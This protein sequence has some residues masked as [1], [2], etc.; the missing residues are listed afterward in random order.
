MMLLDHLAMPS[1]EPVF[2]VE[3]GLHKSPAVGMPEDFMAYLF[4]SLP[5][6]SQGGPILPPPTMK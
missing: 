5:E 2:G 6:T 1:A 4:N 3:S